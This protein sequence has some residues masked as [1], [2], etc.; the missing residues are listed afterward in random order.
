RRPLTGSTDVPNPTRWKIEPAEAICDT[1]PVSDT[2]GV[3]G[4]A[5][6]TRPLVVART[7]SAVDVTA[8]PV[9]ESRPPARLAVPLLLTAERSAAAPGWNVRPARLTSEEVVVSVRVAD[10][11]ATK[12]L[13]P[14]IAAPLAAKN[15]PDRVAAEFELRLRPLVPAPSASDPPVRLTRGERPV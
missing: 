3:A 9:A 4:P 6:M 7:K 14:A 13:D 12:S 5:T 11:I 15:E 8:V 10:L 2:S 1:P